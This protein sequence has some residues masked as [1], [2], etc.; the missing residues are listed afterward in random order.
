MSLWDQWSLSLCVVLRFPSIQV[1]MYKAEGTGFRFGAVELRYGK[2]GA[3]ALNFTETL[4]SYVQ[5]DAH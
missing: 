5:S 3:V 4:Q 2:H 1:S